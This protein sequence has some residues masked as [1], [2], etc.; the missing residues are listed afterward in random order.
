ML[1]N[2]GLDIQQVALL[3]KRKRDDFDK[4][5]RLDAKAKQKMAQGRQ[6]K[7]LE[8]QNRAG[9]STVLMPDVFV[10]NYMKQQRNFVHYKRFK[11]SHSPINMTPEVLA[12][13]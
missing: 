3:K 5:K 8:K 6:K 9:G 4:K 12:K 2:S 10:S 11:K 1:A 13:I 7:L